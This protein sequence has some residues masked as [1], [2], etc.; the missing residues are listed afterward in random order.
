MKEMEQIKQAELRHA[1]M[2]IGYF[3][4]LGATNLIGS[5]YA[6]RKINKQDSQ[7]SLD[8][9]LEANAIMAESI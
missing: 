4:T 1:K 3:G 6:V 5:Y 2:M 7:I 9:L 8:K